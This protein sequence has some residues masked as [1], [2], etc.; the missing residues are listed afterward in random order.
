MVHKPPHQHMCKF[1]VDHHQ[2]NTKDDTDDR[3][4]VKLNIRNALD[5]NDHTDWQA[6]DA[7]NQRRDIFP[8]INALRDMHY[9]VGCKGDHHGKPQ[10]IQNLSGEVVCQKAHPEKGDEFLINSKCHPVRLKTPIYRRNLWKAL[11]Q[12]GILLKEAA[13]TYDLFHIMKDKQDR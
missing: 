13:E 11:N 4:C 3:G 2:S 10:G 8:N 7:R 6:N 12:V 5:Q 9:K 1:Q